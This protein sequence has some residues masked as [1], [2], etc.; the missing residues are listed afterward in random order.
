M[1]KTNIFSLLFFLFP[2]FPFSLLNY[3]KQKK[4]EEERRTNEDK[5]G[6][7]MCSRNNTAISNKILKQVQAKMSQLDKIFP[8]TSCWLIC[9]FETTIL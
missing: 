6:G 4:K 7:M 9:N 2:F 1:K 8:D 3:K 5:K